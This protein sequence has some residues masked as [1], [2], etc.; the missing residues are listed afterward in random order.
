MIHQGSAIVLFLFATIHGII[1]NWVIYHTPGHT[2]PKLSVVLKTLGLVFMVLSLV[3]SIIFHPA[4]NAIG[5]N[6]N[7][8]D[9]F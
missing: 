8:F 2:I 7:A 5:S 3:G 4:S 1:V 9:L 6:V